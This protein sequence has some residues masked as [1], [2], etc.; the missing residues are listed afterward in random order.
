MTLCEAYNRVN[1]KGMTPWIAYGIIK[2]NDGY[3]IL[4]SE[5]IKRFPDLKYLYIRKGEAFPNS[6][7][8]IRKIE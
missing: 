7:V 3:C 5:Y 6:P 4:G 1:S 2:W 8:F